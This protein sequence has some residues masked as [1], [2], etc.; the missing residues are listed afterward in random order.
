MRLVLGKISTCDTRKSLSNIQDSERS[1]Y[2][3]ILGVTW[4]LACGLGP[5]IGGAFS[6]FVTWRWVFW[7]NRVLPI[8]ALP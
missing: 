8:S 4:G 1:K 3:G 2:Y 5:I 6:E 7:I